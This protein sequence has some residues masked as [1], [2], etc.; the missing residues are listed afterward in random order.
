MQIDQK[1]HNG[2]PNLQGML[3][4][5]GHNLIFDPREG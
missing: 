2:L 4:Y 3:P 5:G 1:V